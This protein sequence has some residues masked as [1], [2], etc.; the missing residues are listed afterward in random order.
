VRKFAFCLLMLSTVGCDRLTKHVAATRLAGTSGRSYL[1]STVRLEYAE[2]AGAFMSLG[3]E[4]PQWIRTAMFTIGPGVLFLALAII[5]WKRRLST[6]SLL[7]L[8]LIAAGGMSNVADRIFLGSVV[9]FIH[10]GVGSFRTGIF[11]VADVAILAGIAFFV[12]DLR[13][14]ETEPTPSPDYS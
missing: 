6:A 8:G 2:N 7:G 11:N 12:V 1:A 13:R 4:L 14:T 3:A 9:D 10:I 5:V